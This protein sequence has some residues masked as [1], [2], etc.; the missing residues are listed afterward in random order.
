AITPAP[1]RRPGEEN[2]V[3]YVFGLA[4]TKPLARKFDEVSDAVR[5]E[6][7]IRGQAGSGPAGT[8][9]RGDRRP[10]VRHCSTASRRA[11]LSP[12]QGAWALPESSTS[13]ALGIHRG[14]WRRGSV[15]GGELKEIS[16]GRRKQLAGLETATK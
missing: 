10:P 2:G 1:R 3:N 16:A 14:A 8:R 12:S 15:A 11:S 5:T 13:F 7:F 9:E 6:R 4:G